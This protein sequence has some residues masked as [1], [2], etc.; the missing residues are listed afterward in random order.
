MLPEEARA[1]KAI[2]SSITC[3]MTPLAHVIPPLK[4]S[5]KS[6]LKQSPKNPKNQP[7]NPRQKILVFWF[8]TIYG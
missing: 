4:K 5:L 1:K 2:R 7:K 6:R 8:P 3:R